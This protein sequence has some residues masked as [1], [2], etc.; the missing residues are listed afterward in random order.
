MF[1]R[2]D[3]DGM[4]RN[5]SRADVAR[6]AMDALRTSMYKVP[7]MLQVEVKSGW[8]DA[9]EVFPFIMEDRSGKGMFPCFKCEAWVAGV[10]H[11]IEQRWGEVVRIECPEG[12]V[13][14]SRMEVRAWAEMQIRQR[15]APERDITGSRTGR[16]PMGGIGKALKDLGGHFDGETIQSATWEERELADLF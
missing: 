5:T 10:A 11:T 15:G 6:K 9:S 12:H 13:I 7:Y 4:Q 16:R 2:V 14:K 1:Y 3:E 8:V